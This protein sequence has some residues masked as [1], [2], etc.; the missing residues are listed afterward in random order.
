MKECKAVALQFGIKPM[1]VDDNMK[2]IHDNIAACVEDTKPD[3]IV[4][5][6]SITT[7]FTPIGGREALYKAIDTIPGKLTN[8]VVKWAKKYNCCIVFPTYE[9][10]PEQDGRVYNSAAIIDETGLLGVYRKTHPFTAERLAL[11]EEGSANPGWT[12]PGSKPLCVDTRFGKLGV[13]ICYDG[14]FPELARATAIMG[15]EIIAR[16]SALM[17]TYE[18]W[19]LTN[20][21]RAYDN[22]VYW[23]ASNAVGQDAGGA[24]FFGG[25]M[26]CDPTGFTMTRCRASDEYCSAILKPDALKFVAPGSNVKQTFDHMQD[27]N[28]ASYENLFAK[29]NS[30]FEPSVRVPYKR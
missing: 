10:A 28:C 2:I 21:A 15:A 5:P 6:E 19:E 4:L 3:L 16:P 7:G 23:V 17:R 24:Y 9:R 8:E 27:R 22:H 26:I 25:S 12:T 18:H 20:R 13:V 14:D 11:P 30:A 29:A 1:Q